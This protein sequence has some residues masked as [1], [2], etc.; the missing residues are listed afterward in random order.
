MMKEDVVEFSFEPEGEKG[1]E[2]PSGLKA[3]GQGMARIKADQR[4]LPDWDD[5][6][7]PLSSVKFAV[8]FC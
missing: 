1:E 5:T 4:Y 2:R 7:R 8:L 6:Q 3:G